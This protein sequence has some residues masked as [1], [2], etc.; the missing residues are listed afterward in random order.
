MLEI[1]DVGF[2]RPGG[3]S[4]SYDITVAAGEILAGVQLQSA[5]PVPQH[6]STCDFGSNLSI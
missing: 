6:T 4:F 1:R 3:L 5:W 2:T